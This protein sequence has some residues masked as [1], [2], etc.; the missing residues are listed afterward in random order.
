MAFLMFVILIMLTLISYFLGKRSLMSPWFLLCLMFLATFSVVLINYNKW[1]VSINEYFVLYVTS[2]L[3]A[4]GGGCLVVQALKRPCK[5]PNNVN[6]TELRKSFIIKTKY[7]VNIFLVISAIFTS[8]YIVKLILDAGISSSF[9]SVLRR[10]YEMQSGE[11]YSP[12]FIF[13]QFREVV[14]AIAYLNV[15]RLFIRIYAREDKISIVKLIVPVFLFLVLILISTERNLFLRFAIYTVSI[16]VFIYG[17]NL[18]CKNANL[19]IVIRAAL[20]LAVIVLIFFLLGVAKQYKSS[21][22]DQFSIYSASGLNNFNVWLKDFDGQLLYGKSTFTTF[23]SSLSE[24]LSLINVKLNATVNQ[25]DPFIDYVTPDGYH[26]YSNIFSA[27]KPYVEDFGYLGVIVFPFTVGLFYQWLYVKAERKN[28]SLSWI[29]YCMFIYSVIYFPIL[30]QLFRRF[31][32]GF[33]YEIVW[34]TL[35]YYLVFGRKKSKVVKGR[36]SAQIK[37]AQ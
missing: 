28:F 34:I 27:F 19:K 14:V 11:H 15:F 23:L 25:I 31:H 4:F 13:N 2:A 33:I 29:I 10:I 17:K 7:P 37:G 12:G 22:F 32:L 21:F 5:A 6:A 20:L 9:T 3:L 24:I 30:E 16:W 36:T 8:I 18:H 1:A 35:L 26:Y